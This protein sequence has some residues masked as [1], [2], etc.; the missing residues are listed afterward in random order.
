MELLLELVH[1]DTTEAAQL[2]RQRIEAIQALG[3]KPDWWKLPAFTAPG[4][5]TPIEAAIRRDNPLCRGIL[6]L[7]GGRDLAELKRAL[8]TSRDNPFIQGFAVGRTLFSSAAQA[9]LAGE[10]DDDAFVDR[11]TARYL[12]LA[13]TWRPQAKGL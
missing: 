4:V 10:I 6:L 5:W 2:T 9:W 12:D 7:G 1:P 3:V 13:S 8:A 11:L